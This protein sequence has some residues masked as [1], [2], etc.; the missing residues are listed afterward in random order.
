MSALRQARSTTS[1]S[2]FLPFLAGLARKHAR[3]FGGTAAAGAAAAALVLSACTITTP[4]RIISLS[5]GIQKPVETTVTAYKVMVAR[6]IDDVS[7]NLV[8]NGNLQPMLR[9]VVVVSFSIDANG[10]LLN[11]AVYRTNGDDEAESTALATLR[12]AAPLPPPPPS[13]LN[14]NGQLDLMESWLFND[15]GHFQ[16]ST[17]SPRQDGL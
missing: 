10:H 1:Y 7:A 12:R 16:L 15:D 4:S 11:S 6:R 2:V 17:L 13:L 5:P 8:A 14:G 3:A 9:S